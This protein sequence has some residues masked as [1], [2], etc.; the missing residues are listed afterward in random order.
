MIYGHHQTGAHMKKVAIF[1]FISVFTANLSLFADDSVKQ[2]LMLYKKHQYQN[3]AD[4]LL[5]SLPSVS[6]KAK[7]KADLSLG[8]ICLANAKLY[9]DLYQTSVF[10]N[11][12]YLTKLVKADK[13]SESSYAK[14]YL[15]RALMES[16]E[17]DEALGFLKKFLSDK[18]VPAV[19]KDL[20]RINLGIIH[21]H[22][23]AKAKALKIWSKLKTGDP[24]ILTS[25]AAAY[26][27]F[28][29]EDKKPVSMCGQAMEILKKKNKKPTM[30]VVINI[31][32]V[33]ALAGKIDEGLNLLRKVDLS[34]YYHEENHVKNLVLRFYD[35]VMLKNLSILYGKAGLKYLE[36]AGK[37]GGDKLALSARFYLVEGYGRFGKLEDS[38]RT[39]DSLISS[40]AIPASLAGKVKVRQAVNTYLLGKKK[41]AQQQLGALLQGDGKPNLVAEILLACSRNNLDYSQVLI[42]ASALSQKGENR[43]LIRLNYALGKYYLWKKYYSKAVKHMEAGRDK[44][45]KNRIEYNDPQM[46]I[47]LSEAYYRTKKFSEGLEIYFEMSKQYPAVRQIQVAMQGVYSMVQKSAGDAKI[48]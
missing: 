28:S 21:Y 16:G 40:G 29:L 7:G 42:N 41:A 45:N 33:Y 4:K 3:A 18:R 31:A 13:K 30:P 43:S 19:D 39:A 48:F 6:P 37:S 24:K 26:S 35:P 14:F 47:C 44:S 10:V 27:N 23:G 46:L 11:A 20:A 8:M 12:D 38:I 9:H 15:G 1:L 34:G 17:Y 36:R 2:S 32:G 25:L 5:L 22:K